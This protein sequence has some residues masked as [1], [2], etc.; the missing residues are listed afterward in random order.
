M[1]EISK[2]A[3][4]ALSVLLAVSEKGPRTPAQLARDLQM[5]RTVVHRLLS[6]L[7][8]RGFIIRQ[9]DGYLPGTM[10]VR[11]AERVQPE[12]RARGR[13]TMLQLVEVVAET[14]VLHVRDGDDVLVVEQVVSDRH[15]VRVEHKIGS[16]HPLV[17][18]AS[19]RA[20]LAFLDDAAKGRI[21]RDVD[22]SE[23]LTRQLEG[24]RQLGYTLSHDELQEG[25]HGIAVPVLDGSGH[26]LASMAIL[27]PA[28]RAG[29]VTQHVGAL[30]KAGQ[31][32]SATFQSDLPQS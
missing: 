9:D 18:G 2:T 14:V 32:L 30:L 7:H 10:L 20:I 29:K 17:L 23:A 21:I 16:R 3:D 25:V 8:Q 15:P 22:D 27:V 13:A 19:G 6:T 12:L 1:A 28:S 26:A 4:Q 5:N 11:L 31:E 24:A